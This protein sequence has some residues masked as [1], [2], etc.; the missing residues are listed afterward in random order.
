MLRVEQD[1][2]VWYTLASYA[3]LPVVHGAFT[4]LGG[5]SREPFASLNV[6]GHVGDDPAAVAANHR[7][8]YAA[9]GVD[10]ARVVSAR[11][12][13]G[14]RVARVGD[15][16]VGRTLEATDALITDAPDVLLVLRFADCVP[17]W[18]Y[19]PQHHAIGLAHAGW[20]GTARCIAA[21]T[22]CAMGETFGSRPEDIRAGIGPA[23]GPCCYEVGTD[24]IEALRA[25]IVDAE[26]LLQQRTPHTA[27]LD[28]WRANA[29]QLS[30]VGVTHIEVAGLCT[31]CHVDAF[32]SHRREAGRTGRFAVV[33]GLE[34][35]S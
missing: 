4:R 19:D 10:P 13:H 20:Q 21:K 25:A 24:V 34:E 32:Y 6:G 17:V 5:V 23:I 31:A 22:V 35:R 8:I 29:V 18:L 28:L 1:G 3:G 30:A 16:D 9:L 14:D 7:A 12:V 11:Q 2:L 26:G 33:A 15:A 27:H